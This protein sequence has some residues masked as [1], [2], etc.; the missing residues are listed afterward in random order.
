[1]SVVKFNSCTRPFFPNLLDNILKE[2]FNVIGSNFANNVPAVNIKENESNFSLELA[3]PGLQKEDFRIHLEHDVL[4]ISAEKKIENE[5]KTDKY[6]RREFGYSSFKRSFTL[7][8][9]V[10][11]EKIEAS[12]TDGI[13]SLILPKREE[14]K[15]KPARAI[16]IG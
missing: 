10:D 7:P 1:M 13:L 6:T 14:S 3:V 4:T 11:T 2:D 9:S 5:E 16:N 12:C 15:P 8:K